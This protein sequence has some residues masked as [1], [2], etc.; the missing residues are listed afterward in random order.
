MIHEL[1]ITEC[2]RDAQQ[3]LP[4]IIPPEKRAAYINELMQVGFEVID[5]GSFVSPKAVPQMADSAKVLEGINKE[6]SA[7]RLLAIIGNER[8]ATE[9]AAQPKVDILGFPYSISNTFLERNIHSDSSKAL[10]VLDA[11]TGIA[12]DTGKQLR[13]YISMAFGNP[14]G[15][16]W[17]A[18]IVQDAVYLLAGKGV[19]TITLSDTT[20]LGTPEII[21]K[22]FKTLIP[23][24][25]GVE[26]GLHLHTLPGQAMEKIDAA[27]KA[28]CRSFDGVIN[29]L[30]GCPLTGY[31]LLG[32][33]NT[34]SLLQYCRDH[35]IASGLDEARI[36]KIAAAYPGFNLLKS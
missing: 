9:A 32:N 14:Y 33:V 10:H 29:G 2:P 6:G 13:V 4:Y 26:L 3:G 15:D 20:G 5:F 18:F 8:G 27:W 24:F 31:E 7:T 16:E 36:R 34:L 17:S 28:G 35:K 23:R 1:K 11:I 12:R 19:Q 25:P 21:Y 30:G 22:L